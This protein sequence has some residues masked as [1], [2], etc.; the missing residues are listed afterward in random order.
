MEGR[1]KEFLARMAYDRETTESSLEEEKPASVY[2]KPE[3]AQEEDVSVE[4]AIAIP[5]G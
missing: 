1:H 2:T 3:A 5:V 4:D